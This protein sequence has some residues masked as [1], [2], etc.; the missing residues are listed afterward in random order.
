MNTI[1]NFF[2]GRI[3][4]TLLSANNFIILA[5]SVIITG[6]LSYFLRHWRDRG[7][8]LVY[9]EVIAVLTLFIYLIAMVLPALK[10]YRGYL[11]PL[12]MAL[13]YLWLT[14]L[15]FSSQDYA[16]NRCR[17]FSPNTTRHCGLKHTVQAFHI[18]GFVFLLF[19]TIQEALMW[20]SYRRENQQH[21]AVHGG[22]DPE[23]DRPLTNATGTTTGT[24]Q[25]T[26][27]GA[28]PGLIYMCTHL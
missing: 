23:K 2:N 5:S 18:I 26:T 7:T 28:V 15:I 16:G 25:G 10:S 8:H 11:L 19:N 9:N 13:T 4:R 20:A 22:G 24:T 17:Y 3:A 27:G 21:G 14:S 12:N 1:G 6:I